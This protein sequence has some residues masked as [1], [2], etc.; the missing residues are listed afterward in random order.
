MTSHAPAAFFHAGMA[1][2]VLADHAATDGR[3]SVCALTAPPGTAT[4]LHRHTLED[5][6][7]VVLEGRLGIWR[8]GAGACE[9]G[10]GQALR[11]GR[12]VPHR[13]ASTDDGPARFLL[14]WTPAGFEAALAAAGTPDAGEAADPDD[15]AALF[16][17]A[18][19]WLL[20]HPQR[21]AAGGSTLPG[22]H[23]PSADPR[24]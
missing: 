24:T 19:V 20:P 13:L 5:E 17:R 11:L 18:G 16:A 7:V 10:P 4:P 2:Q 3:L 14:V 6:T 1:V 21:A 9:L 12:E 22:P 15:V 23:V 8:Q